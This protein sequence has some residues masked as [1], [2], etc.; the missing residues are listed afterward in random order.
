M[1]IGNCR[2]RCTFCKSVYTSD[3]YVVFDR[4][5]STRRGHKIP[6]SALINVSHGQ[7]AAHTFMLSPAGVQQGAVHKMQQVVV[8]RMSLY[9]L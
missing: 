7:R 5:F 4:L 2:I 3:Y 6:S 9:C 8:V 1:A